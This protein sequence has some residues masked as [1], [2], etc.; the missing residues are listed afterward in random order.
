MGATVRDAV[1]GVSPPPPPGGGFIET[2]GS[3]ALRPRLTREQI[4]A[5]LP[6]AGAR[7]VFTFP[8]PYNTTGIRLTNDSDCADGQDC[9]WYAGYSYWRNIN[10][11]V[12]SADMYIFLGT[13]PQSRRRRAGSA[14][15]QQGHRRSAATRTA[16]RPGESVQLQH[17]R[18]VVLQR[19]AA[20]DALCVSGWPAAAAAIQHRHAPVRSHRRAGPARLSAATRLPAWRQPPSRSRIRATTIWCTRRRSRMPTG[21]APAVSSYEAAL[22][23][24]SVLRVAERLRVRRVPRRQVWPVGA[25]ARK[26]P[27]AER[28]ATASSS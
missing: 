5:F 25:A 1:L 14:S 24:Y 19:D 8:A 11:H 22:R 20:D 13:R 23:R 6:P 18:R 4:Q 17:R 15:L 27:R 7:G 16:L 21:S 26:P 10:N 12:G 9:L 28:G 3:P 2:A